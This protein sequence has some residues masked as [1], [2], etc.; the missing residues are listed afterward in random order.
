MS[1]TYSECVFVA[2]VILHAKRMRRIILS[3]GLTGSTIFF[4]IVSQ[5]ARFLA[6][7]ILDIKCILIFSTDFVLKISH[8]NNNSARYD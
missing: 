1:V 3:S 7:E 5:T 8:S 6:M 2:L 4:H